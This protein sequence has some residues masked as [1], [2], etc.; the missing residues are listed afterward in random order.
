MFSRVATLSKVDS[1]WLRIQSSARKTLFYDS[2]EIY[3][4]ENCRLKH[5]PAA[6]SFS[7][8]VY[9]EEITKMSRSIAS[10]S[11][12]IIFHP[13]CSTFFIARLSR[14]VAV[15]SEKLEQEDKVVTVTMR[16]TLIRSHKRKSEKGFLNSPLNA[17]LV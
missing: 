2:W 7:A 17:A 9:N 15:K 3:K 10:H 6:V 4:M 13:L 14:I 5:F 1:E 12:R 8:T 11:S 16:A